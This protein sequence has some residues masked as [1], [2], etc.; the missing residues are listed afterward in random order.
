MRGAG[1]AP[2][3]G[4]LAARAAVALEVALPAPGTAAAF[5]ATNTHQ[6]RRGVE[7]DGAER[8]GLGDAEP[9]SPKNDQQGP[10]ARACR[11]LVAGS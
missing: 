1:L 4:A 8:Q 6:S 2:L 11:P 3:G 5:A 7:V 10:V 9:C